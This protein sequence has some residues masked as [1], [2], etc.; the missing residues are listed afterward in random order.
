M[1]ATA[2]ASLD[3]PRMPP[4]LCGRVLD[5]AGRPRF[6]IRYREVLADRWWRV[7]RRRRCPRFP[8][9]AERRPAL[10]GRRQEGIAMCGIAGGVV[11]AKSAMSMAVLAACSTDGHRGPEAEGARELPP[12]TA[13]AS[14]SAT[15]PGDHRPVGSPQPMA[16]RGAARAHIN[17]EIYNFREIPRSWWPRLPLRA[18][19]GHRSAAARL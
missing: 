17:G 1:A 6:G 7:P 15:G 5:R 12:P 16:R 11:N 19:F 3:E 10:R 13:T 14:T 18:R 2:S 8:R 4:A 9:R